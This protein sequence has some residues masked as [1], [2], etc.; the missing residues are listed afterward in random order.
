MQQDYNLMGLNV[1]Q[2]YLKVMISQFQETKRAD[3]PDA[4][5]SVL[6]RM[7]KA[8]LSMS[9]YGVSEH[10]VMSGDQLWQ[11]R[12]KIDFYFIIL[13]IRIHW[14][15]FYTTTHFIE[16]L[17][18]LCSVLTVKAGSHA[19]GSNGSFL[20]GYPEFAG[21]LGKNSSRGKKKRLLQE[22]NHHMNYTISADKTALRLYYL[23]ILREQFLSL[24]K[25]KEGSMVN[26]TIDLMD[27]YGLDRDDL[28][29]NMD[30]FNLDSKSFKFASLDSKAK[31]AFTREYNKRAH[32]SQALVEEQSSGK[33]GKK[34]KASQDDDYENDGNASNDDEE[35]D[36]EEIKKLF[37]KK[38]K[39]KAKKS[40][41]KAGSKRKKK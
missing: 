21:W 18:P 4:E 8:T 10:R 15:N 36:P 31:A 29:E 1:H 17:L 16:K 22:L 13:Y 32:K 38:G 26:E 34:K 33:A 20:P 40:K 19:S 25:H 24:M 14:L 6:D 5:A 23:P 41:A 27:E 7:E 28:F 3:D 11:V 37:Q 2:N 35:D 30:E 39:A 9:D 12:S